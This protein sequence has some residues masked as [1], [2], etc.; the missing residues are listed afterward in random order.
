[1]KLFH[2]A[3]AIGFVIVFCGL[4]IDIAAQNAA[5]STDIVLTVGGEV[6]HPLKLKRARPGSV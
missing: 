4:A 6:D 2:R 3:I 5:T 1:M